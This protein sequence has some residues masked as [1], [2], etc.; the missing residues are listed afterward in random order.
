MRVLLFLLTFLPKKLR[1]VKDNLRDYILDNIFFLN[2]KQEIL[3]IISRKRVI[4]KNY[5]L[6]KR[7][8]LKRLLDIFFISR[9]VRIDHLDTL[10]SG[11]P[12]SSCGK[13]DNN[14]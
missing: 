14:G 5:K 2:S 1:F 12:A 6:L 13:E 7:I 3:S 10:V 11:R 8:Q 4:E 9:Q